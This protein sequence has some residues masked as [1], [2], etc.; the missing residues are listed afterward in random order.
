MTADEALA[1]TYEREEAAV[2]ADLRR[3]GVAVDR[4]PRLLNVRLPADAAEPLL[5]HLR[6]AQTH[7]ARELL[8]RA[9]TDRTFAGMI[10]TDL[11]AL[12][13]SDEYATHR[14]T[15]GQAISVVGTSGDA[16]LLIDLARRREF[17]R[18]REMI[19]I[20]LSKLKT[21]E[22]DRVLL[23]L[24]DD[25]IVAGHAVKALASLS[26]TRLRM[27]DITQ[28]RRFLDDRRGWV[29]RAAAAALKKSGA[30]T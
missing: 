23:E 4:L 7:A 20:G 18:A 16:P 19:V 1:A 12:F 21:N 5:R 8:I 11:V 26:P 24:L 9:M 14:W 15:I 30:T 28:V 29:R 6:T 13:E 10:T 25:D 27:L 3:V 22:S 17:G 2:L